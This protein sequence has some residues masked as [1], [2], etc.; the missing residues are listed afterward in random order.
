METPGI[1]RLPNVGPVTFIKEVVAE[2][3]KVNWPT[4]NETI[5]LTGVVI[6]ISAGV[7]AFIGGLDWAMI[8]LTGALFRR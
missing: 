6:I 7:A 4:R 1:K 2:L 3:K 5:R 8:N